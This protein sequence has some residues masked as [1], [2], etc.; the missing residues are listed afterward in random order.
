MYTTDRD[1]QIPEGPDFL[2]NSVIHLQFTLEQINGEMNALDIHTHQLKGSFITDIDDYAG[3]ANQMVTVN[4]DESGIGYRAFPNVNELSDTPNTYTGQGGKLL[5]VNDTEDGVDFV[6]TGVGVTR[7]VLTTSTFL[8]GG[9]TDLHPTYLYYDAP[10]NL[11]I[12]PVS[13]VI[14][15]QTNWT[16]IEPTDNE[17]TTDN[18]VRVWFKNNPGNIKLVIIG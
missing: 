13:V 7:V 5:A 16:K 11:G 3:H 9:P 1:Y 15:S 14:A 12:R 8:T 17:F 18:I 2:Q 6:T 4:G 10:H